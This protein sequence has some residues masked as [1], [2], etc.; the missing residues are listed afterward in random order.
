MISKHIEE[1]SEE[2]NTSK[3]SKRMK[4]RCRCCSSHF[5]VNA[6]YEPRNI[7]VGHNFNEIMRENDK[8]YMVRRNFF[9]KIVE[10]IECGN[11][12]EKKQRK[13]IKVI[14]EKC[15]AEYTIFDNYI[16]GYDAIASQEIKP[17]DETELKKYEKKKYESLE[18]YVDI[19][20]DISYEEFKEEFADMNYDKYLN[21][22]SNIDIYGINFKNRKIAILAEETA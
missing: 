3:Y 9:G 20:Q 11:I 15:G 17:L 5:I 22:F 10:K 7:N 1:I 16:H 12:F 6:Y 19:Y 8:L 2:I 18:V 4:I 14:C 21:S 13:I